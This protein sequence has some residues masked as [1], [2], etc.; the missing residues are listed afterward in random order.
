M[1]AIFLAILLP[2]LAKADTIPYKFLHYDYG[3][4]HVV[5]ID[6]D[7]ESEKE[8]W[9][10]IPNEVVI[11]DLN[12]KPSTKQ[13]AKVERFDPV[14]YERIQPIEIGGFSADNL[15]NAMSFGLY[16]FAAVWWLIGV[17]RGRV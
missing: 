15:V 10:A 8:P 14:Y 12:I 17:V 7:D 1:K 2:L 4:T 16:V 9:E 11:P 6:Y 13:F 5:M 3:N